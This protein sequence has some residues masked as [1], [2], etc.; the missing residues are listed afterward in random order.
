MTPSRQSHT[1]VYLHEDRSQYL[2]LFDRHPSSRCEQSFY[3]CNWNPPFNGSGTLSNVTRTAGGTV[4]GAGNL[5]GI[6]ITGLTD[7]A[8][9][10]QFDWDLFNGSVPVITQWLAPAVPHRLSKT[11]VLVGPHQFQHRFGRDCDW[12]LQQ[13]KNGCFG[14]DRSCQIWRCPGLGTNWCQSLSGNPGVWPGGG[15]LSGNWR[16][17]LPL[18]RGAGTLERG[19]RSRV[20]QTS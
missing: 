16:T 1:D 12:S 5:T 11:E 20:L 14:P 15:W 2:E 7:G 4:S 18:R 10:M 19:Y 17:R 13:R 9:N 6:G 3:A 8:A